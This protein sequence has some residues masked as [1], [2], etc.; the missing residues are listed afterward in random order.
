MGKYD[1]GELG[2]TFP[3][4]EHNHYS[5]QGAGSPASDCLMGQLKRCQ[6]T[7]PNSTQGPGSEHITLQS[8]T[9]HAERLKLRPERKPNVFSSRG[10]KARHRCMSGQQLVSMVIDTDSN[11][12]K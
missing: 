2:L 11:R 7:L 3:D 8:V 9:T 4:T 6:M 12:L 5:T 10:G 1:S